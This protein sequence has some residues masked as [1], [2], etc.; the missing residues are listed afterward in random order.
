MTDAPVGVTWI[1][2]TESE[3]ASGAIVLGRWRDGAERVVE[4][5]PKSLEGRPEGGGRSG[6]K[7][8]TFS[9]YLA[10]TLPAFVVGYR[11]WP[12]HWA[13]TR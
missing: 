2:V 11:E 5:S 1:A 4:W 7:A 10:N 12:T 9:I 3:P 13:R 8:R 6:D